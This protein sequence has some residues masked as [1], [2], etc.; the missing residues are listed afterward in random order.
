M[1]LESGGWS[2]IGSKPFKFK[3]KC[4]TPRSNAHWKTTHDGL[5]RLAKANRI[6]Q[7]GNIIRYKMYFDDFPVIGLSNIWKDLMGATD[8]HYVVETNVKVIERCLLMTTDI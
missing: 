4:Y 8:M 7:Q 6:L 5:N 3:G 1:S 2:E